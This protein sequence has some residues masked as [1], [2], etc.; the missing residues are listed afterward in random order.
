MPMSPNLL[1]QVGGLNALN[2]V[3][4]IFRNTTEATF[5]AQEVADLVAQLMACEKLFSAEAQAHFAIA[6]ACVEQP[7]ERAQ[8]AQ[9]N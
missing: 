7:E 6:Q 2:V 9:F 1:Q 4:T 3:A 8:R 5:P